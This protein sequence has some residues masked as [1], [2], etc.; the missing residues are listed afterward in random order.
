MI[1]FRKQQKVKIK[2]ATKEVGPTKPHL[3]SAT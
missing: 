2:S 3:D 1:R